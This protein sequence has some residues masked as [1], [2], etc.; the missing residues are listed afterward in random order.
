MTDRQKLD[1][2]E[3]RLAIFDKANWT[4]EV[5]GK[6]L[7]SGQP[8]LAH[9]ISQSKMNLRKYG[10]EVI[11]HTLNLSPVCSLKCNSSVLIDHKTEA[12]EALIDQILADI[13]SNQQ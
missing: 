4:C 3:K 8:Q 6:P 10:E 11:H 5:C 1:I 7:A 13:D 9:R 12:R 2:A